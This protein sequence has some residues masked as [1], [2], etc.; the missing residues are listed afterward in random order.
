VVAVVGRRETIIIVVDHRMIGDCRVVV[1]WIGGMA[2]TAMA[3]KITK[4]VRDI[5]TAI[6]KNELSVL[7]PIIVIKTR[8][9]AKVG[10]GI[11][12]GKVGHSTMR[13]NMTTV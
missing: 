8:R 13:R 7:S 3:E 12:E 9:V 2:A 6:K 10:K 4:V 11:I 1:D 5:I